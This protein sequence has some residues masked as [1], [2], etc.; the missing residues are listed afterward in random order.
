M[1]DL[2]QHTLSKLL[3]LY[4]V[5]L[6]R[7]PRRTE[8][9]LRDLCHDYPREIFVLVHAQKEG[10]PADLLAAPAW[11][12]RAIFH[13]QL[14]RR[15][16]ERL[17]FTPQ[18]ADWA[19]AAWATALHITPN[20]PD[21]VWLWLQ[22]HT[23]DLRSPRLR[24]QL[25][26]QLPTWRKRLFAPFGVY[27]AKVRDSLLWWVGRPSTALRWVQQ[28]ARLQWRPALLFA[29]TLAFC[30]TIA[31]A[32]VQQNR[33]P[34]LAEAWTAPL[35]VTAYP[36]P[37]PAWVQEGPLH[38]RSE[39]ARGARSL[40]LLPAGEAVTVVR[41]S[42]DGAWSQISAPAIG[43]IN[44]EFLRFQSEGIQPLDTRLRLAQ[45]RPIVASVNVRN[46]PGTEFP[47]VG[48]L[49]ADQTVVIVATDLDGG[50]QQI[51]MPVQGWVRSDLLL[52]AQST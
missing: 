10:I 52:V 20:P 34:I 31:A 19:V 45:A 47:V 43:W 15:L 2:P 38:I 5:E 32:S 49:T 50:W 44:N 18:A 27:L 21:R 41:F 12:P 23:P 48:R 13:S 6:H 36:L 14:S 42:G 9:F 51:L 37:R 25:C 33:Q 35:L 26:T 17:A 24:Q 3:L 22:W 29:V 30:I 40:G 11:L 39:P 28:R 4:G 46:G 16:Q 8:A 7:D 1:H